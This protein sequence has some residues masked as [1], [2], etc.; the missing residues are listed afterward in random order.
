MSNDWLVGSDRSDA[1]RER[2]FGIAAKLIAE[3]GVDR[4]D[5]N[6]LAT[7]SHCSRATI[8]RH[9]GGKRQLVET[10]FIRT[11]ARITSAVEQAVTGRTGADRA[12]TA[13]AIALREIRGDRVASQFIQARDVLSGARTACRSPAI[14]AI[15]AELIGLDPGD[16]NRS[17]L[18]VR[19]FL[20]LLLFP[21][22]DSADE[23]N[24]VD[25][26]AAGLLTTA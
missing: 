10:V 21:P 22:A 15:A 3:R 17:S 23:A 20:A 9:T 2:L 24:L 26:L 19:T 18:A 5:L 7:R 1:A 12:R 13:I 25:A 4:F 11:S 14:A 6:E 16:S 8:Y